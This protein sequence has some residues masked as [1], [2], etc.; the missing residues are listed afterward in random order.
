MQSRGTATALLA[1]LLGRPLANHEDQGEKVGPLTGIS[2]FGLDAL[3]SAAYGPEAALTILIAV[4][5]APRHLVPLT[6]GVILLLAIVCTSYLQT[7]PAYPQGGGSYTVASHNLGPAWGLLAGAALMIDYILTVAVGISAGVGATV[8]A[9]PRWQP[10]T[11]PLC[12]AILAIVTL[13]N[14]RGVRESGAIF[15]VPT[16]YFIACMFGVLGLGIWKTLAAGGHPA[17]LV[18]PHH[19]AAAAVP[20]GA[21]LLLK[22][23]SSGCTAMTGVEAVSNGVTTFREPRTKSAQRTLLMIVGVLVIMLAGIA[24]LCRAYSIGATP[25]GSAGYESVLSQITAAVIGKGIFYY[26]TIASILLV[27]ALQA[28]TSFAGFP[29]LCRVIAQDGYLPHSFVNRGRRLVYTPGILVLAVLSFAVLVVFGGVTDRLIPLF[30]VGAFLAFTLSQ[31]GMVAHWRRTGGPH[32]ARNALINGIGAAATGATLVVVIISKFSEG[33]WITILLVPALLV[34]MVRIRRHYA[35]VERELAGP[36]PLDVPNLSPPLVVVPVESWNRISQ[37]ALRVSLA[38]SPEVIAVHV[39]Q[40]EG[41]CELEKK[42]Q[43]WVRGIETER[44]LPP[45][46]LVVLASP[47]RFVI[48]PILDYVL[49]LERTHPD[50]QVAVIVPNLVEQRWYHRFLHNQRGELLTALLLLNG[51]ERIS[52]VN[53]PWYLKGA[54]DPESRDLFRRPSRR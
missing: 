12:L 32:A 31:A 30:A 18:P 38:I 15:I 27:L 44:A 52:I 51:N 36:G 8:S 33:A 23:F 47:Y 35:E 53:V 28:N 5:A 11:L 54:N 16:Y 22:A 24:V 6:F 48:Q 46:E 45:P 39:K 9:L 40:D 41:P 19:A 20:A 3:G 13:V 49:E 2:I 14:L 4:S 37:K 42:W 29:R 7:I 26:L 1:F 10:Y 43:Q 21:W 17:S 50:R 25:P 34:L